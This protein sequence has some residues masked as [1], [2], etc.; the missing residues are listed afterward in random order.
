MVLCSVWWDDG[1]SANQ[2][3]KKETAPAAVRSCSRNKTLESFSS[4]T[5]RRMWRCP[6]YQPHGRPPAILALYIP[7]HMRRKIYSD[8]YQLSNKLSCS[9]WSA[10]WLLASVSEC[11]SLVTMRFS[12]SVWTCLLLCLISPPGDDLHLS[13]GV[14]SVRLPLLFVGTW[15]ACK[16]NVSP[17]CFTSLAL[18]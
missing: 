1:T 9:R 8:L 3:R 10:G 17:L 15:E 18:L 4:S 14:L 7:C 16:Q 5:L 2:T 13:R 6:E 11:V 12:K